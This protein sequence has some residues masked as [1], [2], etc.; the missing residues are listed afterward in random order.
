VSSKPHE[1]DFKNI[2]QNQETEKAIMSVEEVRHKV[3]KYLRRKQRDLVARSAFVLFA[4]V[5]FGIFLMNARITSPRFLAGL[6]TAMLLTSTLW[7]L[8][9]AYQRSRGTWSAVSAGP[10]AAMTSCLDFY[11]SELER[12]REYARQPTWQLVTVMAIIVWMTRDALVRNSTDPFRVLLPYVL[13]AAAG[14]IVLMAVRKLQTRRVQD[15]IDALDVFEDKRLE[16]GSHDT[17][18]DEPQK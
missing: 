10:N 15:D 18:V 6:I 7:S 17:A 4:A 9:R 14:M 12:N 5:S 11:R 16:G 1:P 13:L 8:F 3:R 2:W